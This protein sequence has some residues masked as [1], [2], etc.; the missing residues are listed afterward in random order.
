MGSKTL[1][2]LLLVIRLG[3]TGVVLVL[4]LFL[5]IVIALPTS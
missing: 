4:A 1:A 2:S 3:L 5:G